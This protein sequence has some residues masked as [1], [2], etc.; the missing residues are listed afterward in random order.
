MASG[1][2]EQAIRRV[3]DF[4]EARKKEGKHTVCVTFYISKAFKAAWP[5]KI[6]DSY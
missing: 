6:S 3:V 2:Q 1:R 4:I 5:I